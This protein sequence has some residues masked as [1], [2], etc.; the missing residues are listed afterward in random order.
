LPLPGPD[1]A[2]RLQDDDAVGLAP[3][4]A[5]PAFSYVGPVPGGSLGLPRP[6]RRLAGTIVNRSGD[7]DG[8]PRF[9]GEP[10]SAP[11]LIGNEGR[12]S[13]WVQGK[14][15]PLQEVWRVTLLD[16]APEP[17][18]GAVISTTDIAFKGPETP[19]ELVVALDVG[20]AYELP[21]GHRLALGL[22]EL[23]AA[24][25]AVTLLYDSDRYPSGLNLATGHLPA[26]CR[27]AIAAEAYPPL[28][29][30]LLPD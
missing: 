4:P 14:G 10:M 26:G 7:V 23:S 5:D 21:A 28:V 30:G 17:G 15:L 6:E 29:L 11:L 1:L 3:Y 24:G 22:N 16:L 19:T 2:L 8:N 20:A 9:V 13:L 25:S 18:P 27:P 12:V